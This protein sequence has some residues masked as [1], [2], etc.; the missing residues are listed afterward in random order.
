MHIVFGTIFRARIVL[1]FEKQDR[2]LV[3]D[4]FD[5]V[6]FEISPGGFTFQF[7]LNFV[8]N[9]NLCDFSFLTFVIMLWLTVWWY[10]SICVRHCGMLRLTFLISFL[11]DGWYRFHVISVVFSFLLLFYPLLIKQSLGLI[12]GFGIHRLDFV[13]FCGVDVFFNH[14]LDVHVVS[15]DKAKH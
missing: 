3:W 2:D 11:Y 12:V 4:L 6:N 7:W 5:G 9:S 8:S 10:Q 15:L 14:C 13:F 1:Y